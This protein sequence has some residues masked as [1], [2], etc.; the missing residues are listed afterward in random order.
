ML[1]KLE[2]SSHVWWIWCPLAL[3]WCKSMQTHS[4]HTKPVKTEC[5]KHQGVCPQHHLGSMLR[6]WCWD[7]N[8]GDTDDGD[9]EHQFLQEPSQLSNLTLPFSPPIQMQTPQ[10]HI[11]L[12]GQLLSSFRPSSSPAGAQS[13]PYRPKQKVK[14][15][16]LSCWWLF[17]GSV[18]VKWDNKQTSL[19]SLLLPLANLKTFH[20]RTECISS[21]GPFFA[22]I[23][24]HDHSNTFLGNRVYA[25]SKEMEGRG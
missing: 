25:T 2:I 13:W 20:F 10:P 6:Q 14:S 3:V 22:A 9:T 16:E 8:D 23:R 24:P 5:I 15:A 19:P 1:H 11:F 21:I 7:N 4:L 18:G 12:P 17:A